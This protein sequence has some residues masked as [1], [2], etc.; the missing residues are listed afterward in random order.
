MRKFYNAAVSRKIKRTP[1]RL[2]NHYTTPEAAEVLGVDPATLKYRRDSADAKTLWADMGAQDIDALSQMLADSHAMYQGHHY[3]NKR[4]FN[5]FAR[6]Y[7]KRPKVIAARARRLTFP[8]GAQQLTQLTIESAAQVKK[9]E[10]ILAAMLRTEG[11][12]TLTIGA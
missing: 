9:V 10:K 7:N 11:K 5:K 4:L 8:A 6:L 12:L 3:Y 1:A 2:A